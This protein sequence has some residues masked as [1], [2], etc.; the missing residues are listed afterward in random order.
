MYIGKLNENNELEVIYENH[1]GEKITLFSHPVLEKFLPALKFYSKCV[2][3]FNMAG[4]YDRIYEDIVPYDFYI[5]AYNSFNHIKVYIKKFDIL[6]IE[7]ISNGNGS[8]TKKTTLNISSIEKINPFCELNN[9]IL[10][11]YN[12]L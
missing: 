11:N 2:R 7:Y 4:Y 5:D 10:S 6:N 12:L 1:L 9:K 8:S 3:F